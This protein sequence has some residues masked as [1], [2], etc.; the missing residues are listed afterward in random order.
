MQPSCAIC[1]GPGE[2][3]LFGQGKSTKVLWDQL[4]WGG[5][6]G[7]WNSPAKKF[8]KK[9]SW[10][11]SVWRVVCDDVKRALG[12]CWEVL[13][14]KYQQFFLA[15]LG[16]VSLNCNKTDPPGRRPCHASWYG[17]WEVRWVFNT[18]HGIG[19][20]DLVSR[21]F[22]CIHAHM[23]TSKLCLPMYVYTLYF[24]YNT[25]VYMSK[26]KDTFIFSY[27]CS[28]TLILKLSLLLCH[29]HQ[30]MK[31]ESDRCSLHMK[32]ELDIPQSKNYIFL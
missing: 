17:K 11:I 21:N 12:C 29:C 18:W 15:L 14:F 9:L 28:K 24:L 5:I 2:I 25:Q 16:V 7:H 31:I 13:H 26:T 20:M 22:V 1:Q 6:D 23:C 4:R 8:L 3:C 10:V 30:V 32:S 19:R 27:F